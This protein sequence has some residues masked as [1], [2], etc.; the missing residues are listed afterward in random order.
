MSRYGYNFTLYEKVGRRYKPVRE[1]DSKIMDALPEGFH[2][3]QVKPGSTSYRFDVD[4]DC[5][6]LVAA[7]RIME[8]A[9]V[10]ALQE[11]SQFKPNKPLTEKQLA[12][13][14]AYQKAMGEERY[15]LTRESSWGIVNKGI[16]AL[17]DSIK[18]K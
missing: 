9:M 17:I 5:I 4:P 18:E 10:D 11:E 6:S 12:A 8:D 2:L 3:I 7:A 16:Q 15:T 14:K 1:Y 13:Y